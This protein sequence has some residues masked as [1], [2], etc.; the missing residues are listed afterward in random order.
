MNLAFLKNKIKFNKDEYF[1][2]AL[3]INNL[4]DGKG[5]FSPQSSR[6]SGL[7]LDHDAK[8]IT[9]LQ[10]GNKHSILVANNNEE[11]Q[12]FKLE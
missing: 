1:L 3:F 4:R 10:S 12:I 6:E 5:N 7:F 11:L 9:T 8:K 2:V